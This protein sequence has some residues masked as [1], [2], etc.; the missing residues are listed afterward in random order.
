MQTDFQSLNEHAL[1]P[2]GARTRLSGD[3]RLGGMAKRRKQFYFNCLSCGK[4]LPKE[5][6]AL[7]RPLT[8]QSCYEAANTWA[9]DEQESGPTDQRAQ[10]VLVQSQKKDIG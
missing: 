8:C 5:E 2:L 9:E 6:E 4:R 3:D 10:D 7:F 1:D